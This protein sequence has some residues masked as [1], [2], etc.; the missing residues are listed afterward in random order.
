MERRPYRFSI[1]R[2]L[3][4][5]TALAVVIAVARGLSVTLP[6][7]VVLGFYFGT[8]AVWAVMRWPEVYASLKSVRIRHRAILEHRKTLARQIEQ[9]RHCREENTD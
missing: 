6:G 7:Q 9:Q 4:L 8:L 1:V 3:A 5:T 2:L